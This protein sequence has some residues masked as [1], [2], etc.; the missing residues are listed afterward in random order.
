MSAG[1]FASG[2]AAVHLA[3]C[4][5]ER[6]RFHRKRQCWLYS[7]DHAN[8]LSADMRPERCWIAW[9]RWPSR[10]DASHPSGRNVASGT[11]TARSANCYGDDYGASDATRKHVR[12]SLSPRVSEHHQHSWTV[13][14]SWRGELYADA[15]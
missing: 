10:A 8:F 15:V 9:Q 3:V 14:Q 12:L 11:D 5:G 4:P 7:R 13:R 6:R 2:L 1:V